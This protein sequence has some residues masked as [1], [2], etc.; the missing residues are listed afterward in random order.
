MTTTLKLSSVPHEYYFGDMP[1]TLQ[2]KKNRYELEMM[3]L[4]IMDE[5]ETAGFSLEYHTE[6]NYHRLLPNTTTCNEQRW[7]VILIMKKTNEN[8][9]IWL[10]GALEN[11][12]TGHI[13][14]LTSTNSMDNLS[15]RSSRSIQSRDPNW[16][17]GHYRMCAPMI[18][19]RELVNRIRY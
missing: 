7:K 13:A 18:F 15:S 2:Y 12:D 19:W 4:S 16:F 8:G 10:K 5:D 17:V 14:L 1:G 3:D 11:K 9:E 6:D